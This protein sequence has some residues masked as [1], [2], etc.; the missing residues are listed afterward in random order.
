MAV[1]RYHPKNTTQNTTKP[2]PK[3]EKKKKKNQNET[4][5][6]RNKSVTRYDSVGQ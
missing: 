2:N 3:K 4:E 1:R 5:Q 6:K